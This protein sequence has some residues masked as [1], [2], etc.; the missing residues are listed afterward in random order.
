[1][2]ERG[3]PERLT[4]QELTGLDGQPVAVQQTFD[5]TLLTPEEVDLLVDLARAGG[6]GGPARS[7]A[8]A[9]TLTANRSGRAGIDR[10]YPIHPH[11]APRALAFFLRKHH[12]QLRG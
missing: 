1:L 6:A 10:T 3:L 11:Y 2:R 8:N 4:R 9:A 12:S 7:P 5:P